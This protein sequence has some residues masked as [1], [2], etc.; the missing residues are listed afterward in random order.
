MTNEREQEAQRILDM[1][2]SGAVAPAEGERLLQALRGATRT[3]CPYCAEQIPAADAHCPECGSALRIQPGQGGSRPRGS[4]FHG[5]PGLA[6]ALVIYLF[7]VGGVVLISML[8]FHFGG[9]HPRIL[10]VGLHPSIVT[11]AGL[12][13]MA[14]LAGVLIVRGKPAGWALAIV[15]SALQVVTVFVN[16]AKLNL[17]LLHVGIQWLT[18]G[19]GFGLNIWAVVLVCL[20]VAAKG[21]CANR[22]YE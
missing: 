7:V 19:H 8:G 10:S 21:Q 13:A 14:I 17:Q 1:V 4:G 9:I 15:W 11:S 22:R 12:A 3:T 18:N 20:F 2:E 16:G 6:K 5:L